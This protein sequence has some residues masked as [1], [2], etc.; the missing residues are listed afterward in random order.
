MEMTPTLLF[1]PKEK[2]A[3]D[4][5]RKE[6]IDNEFTQRKKAAD[7]LNNSRKKRRI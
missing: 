5:P 6:R 1:F 7:D 2:K 4:H 3:V